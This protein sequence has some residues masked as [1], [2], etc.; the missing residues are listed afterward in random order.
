VGV[1]KEI[2]FPGKNLF[3]YLQILGGETPYIEWH[4][5]TLCLKGLPSSG[6]RYI[7]YKRARISKV[8]VYEG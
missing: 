5:W 6:F 4:K 7:L 3:R 1:V 8:K 2:S